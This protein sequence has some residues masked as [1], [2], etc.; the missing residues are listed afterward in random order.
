MQLCNYPEERIR[1]E[2]IVE[3][4]F[5]VDTPLQIGS[6]TVPPQFPE[7]IDNVQLMQSAFRLLPLSSGRIF[8]R[9]AD[10]L[11]FAHAGT[12]VNNCEKVC[13]VG[14]EFTCMFF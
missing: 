7:L 8:P 11:Y 12:G 4:P 9:K 10:P 5:T 14:D 13:C 6:G 1:Q 2:T 3:L